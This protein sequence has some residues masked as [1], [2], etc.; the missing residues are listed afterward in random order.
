MN[1]VEGKYLCFLLLK[2]KQR[3]RRHDSLKFVLSNCLKGVYKKK[4]KQNG[5]LKER[6]VFRF[7]EPQGGI[8]DC[9]KEILEI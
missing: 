8:E 7:S 6:D 5:K 3:K 1:I 2:R 9:S 4:I